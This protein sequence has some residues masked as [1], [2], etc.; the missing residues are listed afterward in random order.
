M[1]K[2]WDT[3]SGQ[4][5]LALSGHNAEVNSIAFSPDGKLLASGSLDKTVKLWDAIRGREIW[6]VTEP[7]AAVFSVAFSPDGKRL[8]TAGEDKTVRVWD[9]DT[10]SESRTLVSAPTQLLTLHGHSGAVL[11]VAFSSDGQRLASASMDQTI[12]VWHASDGRL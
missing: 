8:A 3:A 4:M 1:I 7:T 9:L 5:T 10:A 11:S 2:V 6:T 12:K